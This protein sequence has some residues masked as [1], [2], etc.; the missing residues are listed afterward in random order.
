MLINVF[1]L[2]NSTEKHYRYNR[3]LVIFS[4][5]TYV[6]QDILYENDGLI[7]LIEWQN[8]TLPENYSTDISCRK[9][10][11]LLKM[12]KRL[13]FTDKKQLFNW[14]LL[15]KVFLIVRTR[16]LILTYG[17]FTHYDS[18]KKDHYYA[19]KNHCPHYP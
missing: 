14:R 18:M 2:G 15:T 8:W 1:P 17:K 5:E 7:L 11:W 19:L 4:I 3:K 10:K 13:V 9:N 16:T 12:R 6:V